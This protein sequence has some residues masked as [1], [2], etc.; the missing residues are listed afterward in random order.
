MT[1]TA[2]Q[3][4]INL[5]RNETAAGGN[6]KTRVA[7]TLEGLWSRLLGLN[8]TSYTFTEPLEIGIYTPA[9]NPADPD[10]FTGLR[11][12]YDGGEETFKFFL[13]D[14]RVISSRLEFTE[15]TDG[16]IDH[17]N[18]SN[19]WDNINRIIS[20]T[21]TGQEIKDCASLSLDEI[22]YSRLRRY[23]VLN[24]AIPTSGIIRFTYIH[25][26][27][28]PASELSNTK[29]DTFEIYF[30][31]KSNTGVEFT[32]FNGNSYTP[33]IAINPNTFYKLTV[34]F[35]HTIDSPPPTQRPKLMSKIE[36][37]IEGLET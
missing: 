30:K 1:R 7:D 4:L 24:S 20:H 34:Y 32:C 5:I 17:N 26:D 8:G 2:L 19:V 31:S 27:S 12:Y 6:T 29:G 15:I 22:T 36:E 37:L 25:Y 33:T 21:H 10:V 16:I 9:P 3:N 18:F 35:Y 28:L 14:K 23:R 11:V 13:K